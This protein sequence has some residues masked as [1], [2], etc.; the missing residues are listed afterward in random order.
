MRTKPDQ[1]PPA[2]DRKR[3]F[4]DDLVTQLEEEFGQSYHCNGCSKDITNLVRI[5]CAECADFDLCVTCFSAGV[6][7]SNTSHRNTHS[8]RVMEMLDFEIF[9]DGW[10]A[11]EELKLVTAIEHYGLGNWEQVAE[12]VGSKNRVECAEHYHRAYINSDSFPIPDMTRRIDRNR[13][14]A[15]NRGPPRK[16]PKHERPPVSQPACHEIHG[17]MPGRREFELECDNE[18]E[19]MIK[20]IEFSDSDPPEEIELK[21]AMFSMYNAALDRRSERKKFVHDRAI[22][23]FKK[24]QQTEKKRYKE[25]KELYQKLRVFAKMQTG[26]DFEEF[27]EGLLAEAKIR[28]EIARLQEYRRMGLRNRS[29][30]DVYER[31]KRDREIYKSH[32]HFNTPRSRAPPLSSRGTPASLS[33]L[34]S[35]NG[36]PSNSNPPPQAA[37]SSSLSLSQDGLQMRHTPP[38][39]T[40]IAS[41]PS[42]VRKPAAPLDITASDGFD[43]LTHNERLLCANLRLLPRAYIQIKETILREYAKNGSLRRRECRSLI[44]IDVNKTSRIYDFFVEMGWVSA[45]KK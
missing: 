15:S 13:R 32:H 41:A 37:L 4:E 28:E 34:P 6:E 26:A 3:K 23:D 10:G 1:E 38:P 19:L 30:I 20:D 29:E 36:T 21:M 16:I 12:Q 14:L 8:Y 7:P 45:R 35:L 22:V 17:Y 5:R 33:F 18:A 25:E 2:N 11:D 39:S 44:K 9:D 43:L 40:A 27:M 24:V 42:G 31:D